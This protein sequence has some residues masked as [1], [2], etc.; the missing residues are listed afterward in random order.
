M[1]MNFVI[2]NAVK[3]LSIFLF[4]HGLL[5]LNSLQSKPT[6]RRPKGQVGTLARSGHH[7]KEEKILRFAQNDDLAGGNTVSTI[8]VVAN[9]LAP[10]TPPVS[11]AREKTLQMRKSGASS[12]QPGV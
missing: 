4:L 2:L 1:N 6:N 9:S 11:R 10:H 3:D 7:Q 8:T 5:F 12:R